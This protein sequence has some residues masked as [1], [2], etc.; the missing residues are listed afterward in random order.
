MAAAPPGIM[1][2][3]RTAPLFSLSP[4]ICSSGTLKSLAKADKASAKPK[5]AGIYSK[6]HEKLLT[7]ETARIIHRPRL[8]NGT[9]DGKVFPH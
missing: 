1:T 4:L 9:S 7:L 6:G 3:A 2:C 5:H 8:P